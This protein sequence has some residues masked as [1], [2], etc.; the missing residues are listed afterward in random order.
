MLKNIYIRQN[1]PRLRNIIYGNVNNI[2]IR[3]KSFGI[4]FIRRE[5]KEIAL[6]D[7]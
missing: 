6:A 5:K 3:K 4:I 1:D 2:M 7:Q